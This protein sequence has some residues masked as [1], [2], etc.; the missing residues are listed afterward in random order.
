MVTVKLVGDIA[1]FGQVSHNLSD[2]LSPFHKVEEVLAGDILVGNLEFPF[3]ELQRPAF[4]DVSPHHLTPRKYVDLILGH[5]PFDILT[6]ANNHIMDWGVEGLLC[7]LGLL[8]DREIAAVGAGLNLAEARSPVI[9]E[10]SG[11]RFGFLGNAKIGPWTA[12]E[13]SPGASPLAR[14]I[15]VPDIAYLKNKVDF[16]I[17]LSHWGVEFCSYPLNNDIAL[18]R[19]FIDAGADLV[20]GCHAH[21]PQ[22]VGRYKP[23][24]IFYGLGS[25]IYDPWAE[26]IFVEKKLYER[27][28]SFI[29]RVGFSQTGIEEHSMIPCFVSESGVTEPLKGR[30]RHQAMAHLDRISSGIGQSSLVYEEAFGN[31]AE[32]E[33]KTFFKYLME[34]GIKYLVH[35]IGA[36][37]MR[38]FRLM[39]GYLASRL[40]RSCA[41]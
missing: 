3:S 35:R 38:H 5:P 23:G 15:V 33:L 11:L 27:R 12:S 7:T 21:V 6:L 13:T 37:K 24:L 41:R 2:S 18:G 14:D 16:V 22:G 34:G 25:F 17:V 40:R 26:R 32:R 30:A 28:L 29:A 31:L 10:K 19:A 39:F 4:L 20:V 1:V 36:L 9:I 8:R